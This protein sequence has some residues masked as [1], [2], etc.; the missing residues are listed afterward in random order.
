[1]YASGHN[2]RAAHVSGVPT[3][4]VVL[5]AYVLAGVFAALAS[6]LY[7]GQAETG[8]PVMAQRL[9]LEFVGATVLGGTSLFV[10]K[11]KVLWTVL[12]VLF[13]KLIDSSLNLLDLSYFTIMMVKGL[14]ILFAAFLDAVRPKI[15]A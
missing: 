1:L 6:M 8:S 2:L 3:G 13:I 15:P 11:G 12:G 14:V 10:G 5:S 7:T 9:L 4:A